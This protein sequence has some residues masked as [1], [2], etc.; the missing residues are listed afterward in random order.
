MSERFKSKYLYNGIPLT[1]HFK[2]EKATDF[3]KFDKVIGRGKPICNGC[4]PSGY[5]SLVPDSILGVRVTICG[6]IHN[7]SYQFGIDH[8]DKYIADETFGDNMDRI[9]R[10]HYEIEYK[11]EEERHIQAVDKIAGG[12]L[13]FFRTWLENRN[14]AK[15]NLKLKSLY[16]ARLAIADKVYEN[17][18]KVFGRSA[19]WDKRKINFTLEDVK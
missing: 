14:H 15:N 11:V 13:V 12:I 10:A 5:G 8:E 9:I 4:G 7:W 1:C 17:A 2:F 16:E 3:Q 18:V 19:F 6:H